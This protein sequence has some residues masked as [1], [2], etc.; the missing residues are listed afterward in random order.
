MGIASTLTQLSPKL[1]D[2]LQAE[3][4]FHGTADVSGMKCFAFM[5]WRA[6]SHKITRCVRALG[7]ASNEA[8]GVSVGTLIVMILG[9]LNDAGGGRQV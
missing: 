7:K 4:R 3:M 1:N 9:L 2:C 5:I 6:L 8:N